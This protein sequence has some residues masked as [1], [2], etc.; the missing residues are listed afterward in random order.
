MTHTLDLD[1]YLARIGHTGPRA[2]TLDTLSAIQA[3]H[4]E[5]I[6][7]ENLNPLFGWPVPIDL[8]SLEQKLVRDR[9][10]GYCFEQNALFAHALRALGFHVAGL[11]A[12]VLWGQPE[13]ARTA[14]THMLLR[15]DLDGQAYLADVGFGGQTLTGPLRLVPDVEQA[16]PHEPYRLVQSGDFFTMQ[17]RIGDAWKTLYRFTLEEHFPPD[18]EVGNHYVATHPSSIFRNTLRV[19]RATPDRRYA[20]L[21]RDLAVHHLG[22]PTERRTLES[23]ADLRRTL[24]DVFLLNVPPGPELEAAF[25]RLPEPQRA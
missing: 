7:F 2:P 19:A 12:R 16:T 4:V 9:R 3:R 1:A 14:R 5:A 18:Y 23:A 25:E 22:G 20:L 6:A 17:C 24:E 8:P 10:G 21:N 13:D 11:A 15:I